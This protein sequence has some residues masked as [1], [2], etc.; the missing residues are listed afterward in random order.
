MEQ[1]FIEDA[2]FYSPFRRHVQLYSTSLT[3]TVRANF[4][5]P[6]LFSNFSTTLQNT[7]AAAVISTISMTTFPPPNIYS[8]SNF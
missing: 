8:G 6:S 7:K 3:S 5:F 1:R 2:K 4:S